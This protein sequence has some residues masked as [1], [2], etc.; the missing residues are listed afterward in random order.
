MANYILAIPLKM[1]KTNKICNLNMKSSLL[2]DSLISNLIITFGANK[3][4]ESMGIQSLQ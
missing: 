1:N 4:S 3:E 2:M